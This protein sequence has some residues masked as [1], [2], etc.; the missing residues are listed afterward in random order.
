MNQWIIPTCGSFNRTDHIRLEI[1]R[2]KLCVFHNIM[3]FQFFCLHFYNSGLVIDGCNW[4]FMIHRLNSVH[5]YLFLWQLF[6]AWSNHHF[7]PCDVIFCCITVSG[8]WLT[9]MHIHKVV[10][11]SNSIVTV[12]FLFKRNPNG[13]QAMSIVL[14]KMIRKVF[15]IF[16]LCWYKN[17]LSP[18]GKVNI[19]QFM[20]A[21]YFL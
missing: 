9:W 10:M 13:E 12:Q 21:A 1:N 5:C 16:R 15:T 4:F 8:F 7:S 14:H 19:Q 3:F 18:D 6:N 17:V 11:L 20:L 2:F